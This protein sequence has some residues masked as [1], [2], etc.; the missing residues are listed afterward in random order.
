MQNQREEANRNG[1]KTVKVANPSGKVLYVGPRQSEQGTK[2]TTF[3][4]ET[5]EEEIFKMYYTAG[6]PGTVNLNSHPKIGEAKAIQCIKLKPEITK[7][8]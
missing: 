3:V 7:K 8:Y 6:R 5:T 2:T 4:K 1:V